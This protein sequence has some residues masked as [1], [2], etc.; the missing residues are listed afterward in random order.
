MSTLGLTLLLLATSSHAGTEAIERCREAHASSATRHI[1]CLESALRGDAIAETTKVP[2]AAAKVE[3]GLEQAQARQRLPDAEPEQVSVKIVSVTY[4]HEGRGI[5]RMADGQVWRETEASPQ[6]QRLS[7]NKEYAARI[8][9]GRIS[10]YR[11]YV[12]G[13]RRMIKLER[14]Q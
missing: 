6:H 2:P 12:E 14:L 1:A 13:V 3:L 7:A 8:E 10:G 5:F 9:R 11:M 4:N